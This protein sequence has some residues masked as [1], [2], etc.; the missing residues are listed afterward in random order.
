M[1]KPRLHS[2]ANLISNTSKLREQLY[3]LLLDGNETLADQ[4]SLKYSQTI[5]EVFEYQITSF[6]Q[7]EQKIAFFFDCILED[8]DDDE[9]L[10]KCK[11]SLLN[12]IST[13]KI[14]MTNPLK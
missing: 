4:T 3:A 11:H 8:C 12:D 6:T 5:D 2:F 1:D 10:D 14:S 7:F 13:I 9:L